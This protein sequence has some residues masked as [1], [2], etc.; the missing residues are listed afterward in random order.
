MAPVQIQVPI[1]IKIF[2]PAQAA[3]LL[4]HP[5]ASAVAFRQRLVGFTTGKPLRASFGLIFSKRRSIPLVL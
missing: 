1:E 4:R 5:S 3:K 2:V